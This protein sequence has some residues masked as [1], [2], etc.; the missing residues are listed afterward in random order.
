MRAISRTYFKMPVHTMFIVC[1]PLFFFLFVLAYKPFDMDVFLGANA[2]RYTLN[3]IICTL[4]VLGVE[5]L[6]RMLLFI[7]RHKLDLNWALYVIWCLGEA[8][9]S[10]LFMSILLGISWAGVRPYFSV[11]SLC[12]LYTAGILFFPLSILS[13]AVQIYELAKQAAV[14]AIPDEKTLIRFYD[15]QKRLKL[16][17]A[18][19]AVLYIEAE[20][21]Y[22][23]IVHLDNGRIKDFNLRAS[24]RSLEDIVKR[25]GLVRCHRSFFLNA[26][27]V[28]LVKKDPGGYAVA[29]LDQ[30]GA[31]EIP[32]SKRY[33]QSVTALL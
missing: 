2:G 33:Y 22:V 5:S 4:I 15:D 26:A 23:H 21:N 11:M 13:M 7:L 29:Q 30:D 31:R 27:H 18:S 32:V 19:D 14:S 28:A 17:V 20:D 6:S 10:G 12:V 8:V 1:V 9:V 25:H 3:L 24:M 16:V